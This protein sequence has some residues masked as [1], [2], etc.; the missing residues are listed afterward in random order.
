MD[1]FDEVLVAR[2]GA[3]VVGGQYDDL[4]APGQGAQAEGVGVGELVRLAGDAVRGDEDTELDRPAL[5]DVDEVS[6][7]AAVDSSGPVFAL[8]EYDLGQQGEAAFGPGDAYG[9]VDLFGFE[10]AQDVGF[11]EAAGHG[12]EQVDCQGL[13]GFALLVGVLGGGDGLQV[14]M[15]AGSVKTYGYPWWTRRLRAWISRSG[16]ERSARSATS[17]SMLTVKTRLVGGILTSEASAMP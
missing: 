7:G 5:Q 2:E 3:D 4:D 16:R 10:H 12:F 15:D 8:D 14:A 11:D 6:E 17:W 13:V 9:D 1:Q